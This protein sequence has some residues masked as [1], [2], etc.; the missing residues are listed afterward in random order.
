MPR[1]HI[2][3]RNIVFH[4]VDIPNGS[5]CMM[6]TEI[7]TNGEAP[8]EAREHRRATITQDHKRTGSAHLDEPSSRSGEE[9]KRSLFRRPGVIVAAAAL[10]IAGIGYGGIVMFHSFTH[11]TTDDAFVD[12]H[13]VSVAPK[14]AGHVAVVRVDDNQLV[15]KG[16]VLVE[17]DPRDSHVARTA[18]SLGDR[19]FQRNATAKHAAGTTCDCFHRRL[20]RTQVTRTCR[21]HSGWQWRGFHSVAAGKR[22]GQLC[23]SSPTRAGE[24]RTR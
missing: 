21:Q 16:D 3:T 7:S 17:I 24:D 5:L 19:Q 4:K 2:E 6:K 14:V 10:A 20:P 18:T 1:R 22:D 13:T 9:K 15:K 23:E 11:E 12:V 8:I